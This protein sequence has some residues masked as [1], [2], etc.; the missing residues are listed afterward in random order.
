MTELNGNRTIRRSLS[1]LGAGIVIL[2]VGLTAG[3]LLGTNADGALANAVPG[4]PPG[5]TNQQSTPEVE[6]AFR[7]FWDVWQ[8]IDRNYYYDLPDV[9]DR[10]YSAITGL[11]AGLG[12]DYSAFVTPADAASLREVLSNE[13]AGIGAV[14]QEADEG[15]IYINRVFEGSPADKAGMLAGDIVVG[16]NGED[17]TGDILDE[18]ITK[19]RGPAGTSVIL[20][21]VRE[22]EPTPFDL[23]VTRAVVE[24]PSVETQILA[25]RVGYI[26]LYDFYELS[27]E[28]MARA[29]EELL[30]EGVDGLILDVRGNGG[31]YLDSVVAIADLF[32]ADGAI[33]IER[34]SDG[35]TT[36]F[37][38]YRGDEAE[39]IPLVLLVDQNSASASEILAGAIQ[40]RERG[41][42]VGQTTFGKGSVQ[43]LYDLPDLSLLRLTTANWFTPDDRSIQGNGVTPD[44][45]VEL[46]P[47]PEDS[48]PAEFIDTQLEAALDALL[49]MIDNGNE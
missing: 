34:E 41:L 28:R 39:S 29:V 14:V 6:E 26:I 42:V 48:D 44:L 16:V 20:T 5:M 37:R 30:E 46:P 36:T 45:I 35:S 4:L 21:I 18:T 32:L 25:D 15:G 47:L 8:K 31:G 38:S 24:Y 12:D 13:Y 19:V 3:W 22:G 43:S 49:E 7:T 10:A 23:T 2:F 40:D 11:V 9:Q 33:L 27:D 1:L 17:I